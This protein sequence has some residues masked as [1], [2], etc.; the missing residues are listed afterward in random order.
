V[1]LAE[2]G[3]A[4]VFTRQP[5][6]FLMHAPPG[7]RATASIE[8]IPKRRGL[9]EL[10]RYQIATGFPFG[11]LRRT[12]DRHHAEQI[13]V[14]PAIGEVDRELLAR[15]RSAENSGASMRPREGGG[16]EFYGVREY[17]P[18]DSPRSIYWRRSARTGTLVAR[19]MTQVAPPRLIVLVDTHNP[20]QTP[21]R[22]AAVEM[23][24]AQG[25]SLASQAMESGLSVGLAVWGGDRWVCIRPNRGKRHRRDLLAA[26]ARVPLNAR[27]DASALMEAARPMVRPGTTPVLLTSYPVPGGW[28]ENAH[29]GLLTIESTSD[30]ARRWFRFADTVD[31]TRCMPL[32][33][34]T[35]IPASTTTPGA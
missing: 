2:L 20:D 21:L 22:Y 26:L 29:S 15:C 14:F 6:A 23:A 8:L 31:F 17:R 3:A 28:S 11:F 30:Q 16:D 12:A 24:I 5:R 4:E 1:S 13:L 34:G 7:H 19:Q 10:G 9:H 35:A 25:A 32:Y 27:R 18:G 33:S